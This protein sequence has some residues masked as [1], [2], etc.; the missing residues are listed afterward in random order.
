MRSL[1]EGAQTTAHIL[2]N[3]N[4]STPL[5]FAPNTLVNPTFAQT[6][7]LTAGEMIDVVVGPVTDGVNCSYSETPL[8]VTIAPVP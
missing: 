6:L 3:S 4:S 5:F 8:S 2:R 7:T 1:S